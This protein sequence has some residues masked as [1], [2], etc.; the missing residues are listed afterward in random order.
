MSIPT[1]IP[2][3][4]RPGLRLRIPLAVVSG[5]RRDSVTASLIT[6]GLL[7]KF[8]VLICAEDCKNGKPDPE[9]FLLAAAHLKV[10]AESCLVFEDTDM[11]IQAAQAAGMA[12]VKV[13]P[14]GQRSG[15]YR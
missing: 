2:R 5:S 15:A 13:P 11:G 7:E 12:S 8:D 10:P 1:A 9:P 6:L 4:A 14:P 3:S